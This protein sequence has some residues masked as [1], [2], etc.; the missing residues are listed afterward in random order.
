VTLD[1]WVERLGLDLD[2]LAF[3]KL[4]AQGSEVHI[5]RGAPRVLSC[6][7]V[8]WQI[9]IDPET[10]AARGF[11]ADD[12]YDPL[13]RHFTHFI[14]LGH[15]GVGARVHPIGDIA[16]ALPH[17]TGGSAGRTDILAFNLERHPPYPA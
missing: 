2:E 3:V 14:D 17:A 10:L 15:D 1:T 11:T 12:L 7:H 9:E 13:R 6:R 16:D 5:L 4:D 8:A